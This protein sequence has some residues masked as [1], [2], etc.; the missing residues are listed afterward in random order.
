MSI[1]LS[2][3]QLNQ[4][5]LPDF[6]NYTKENE[7]GTF[8]VEK[9]RYNTFYKS[10]EFFAS[11]FPSGMEKLPAFQEIVEKMAENAKLPLEAYN[12]RNPEQEEE[13]ISQE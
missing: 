9:L 5:I 1:K 7:S 13:K 11:K 4:G 3:K 12:E 10:P 6:L 8:D 2:V